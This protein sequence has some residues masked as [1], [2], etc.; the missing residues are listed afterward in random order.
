VAPK[1]FDLQLI[2]ASP[3]LGFELP[4]WSAGLKLVA[5]LDEAGRGALAGPVS[6]AAVILPAGPEILPALNGVR[7]S[8]QM[9]PAGRQFWAQRLQDQALC[10]GVGFASSEEIDAC[11]ILPATR[12][13]MQRALSLLSATPQHLLLDFLELPDLPLPQTSLVKGDQRSLSIAAA[14]VLAK[15][16]RDDLMRQ[17]DTQYPG[18]GFA[19]HKGYGTLAHR[20]ALQAL[21]PSPVHRLT[22]HLK[23]AQS[24]NLR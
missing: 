13:A 16:A 6:A 24:P 22:F 7:D 15:T 3:D 9:T 2:P 18:Y 11:G 8:K 23:S 5:G 20:R 4:L 21:G 14:S 17:L 19:V 12:L 10:Y 1:K